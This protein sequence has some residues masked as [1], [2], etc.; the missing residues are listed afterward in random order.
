MIEALKFLLEFKREDHLVSW[1][2]ALGFDDPHAD[3]RDYTKPPGP[4]STR[5]PSES[6]RNPYAEYEQPT[7]QSIIMLSLVLWP[8]P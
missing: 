2:L 5:S 1:R 4:A 8:R 7:K 6:L 3:Q